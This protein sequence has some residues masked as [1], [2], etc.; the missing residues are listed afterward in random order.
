M[1]LHPARLIVPAFVVPILR[2]P[3]RMGRPE[4]SWGERGP[5][6]VEI[7]RVRSE[8][9]WCRWSLRNYCPNG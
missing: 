6:A 3:R 5:F 1:P 8:W 7:I 2:K 9:D 4:S